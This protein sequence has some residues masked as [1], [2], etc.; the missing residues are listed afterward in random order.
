VV[1][2]P[3]RLR[4]LS[5]RRRA[6]VTGLAA[7]VV[8]ACLAGVVLAGL[9]RL[10]GERSRPAQDRPGPVFLLPG[11]GGGTAGLDA[12]AGRIR[13]TGRAATV[14]R[15]PGDGT[16]DLAEQARLLDRAVEQALDGGA[17]SV[18][19]VGYSAG[20]VVARL[21]VADH[22]GAAKARRIVTLA[23]PHHGTRLAGAG[24]ALA[25]AACPAAC[26]QLAPGS[27]VMRR[28]EREPLA[29]APAWMSVWTA[30]DEVV[31]PPES[32]RLDGAL[33]VEL[34]AVCPDETVAHGDVPG[35]ALVAG[36]V[37][38]ALGAAPLVPPAAADCERL[39][40]G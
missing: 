21:W 18:D 8:A 2:M 26:Q 7:V 27:M 28:L 12:L 22:D 23:S 30:R 19:V 11:Y 3:D 32:S 38:D 24:T 34:Q 14:L 31:T 1:R 13:A 40:R 25:P 33:N 6:L 39:R 16:G 10:G 17:P 37:L 5:P 9:A 35:N 15:P 20:G 36:I 29:A 4:G